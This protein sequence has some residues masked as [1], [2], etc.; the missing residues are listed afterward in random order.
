M[1]SS[2]GSDAKLIALKLLLFSKLTEEIYL[3][4]AWRLPLVIA[5]K[6]ALQMRFNI[7][8]ECLR[9]QLRIRRVVYS[10]SSLRWGQVMK[11]ASEFA[12][13]STST[14]FLTLWFFHQLFLVVRVKDG[15]NLLVFLFYVLEILLACIEVMLIFATVEAAET[16]R[17]NKKHKL[18]KS[19]F[20]LYSWMHNSFVKNLTYCF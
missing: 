3:V 4:F 8:I 2:L 9:L 20:W 19:L 7:H 10:R 1:F 6:C 12:E 15:S 5:L 17:Q 18:V 11:V 16:K 14:V 13:F